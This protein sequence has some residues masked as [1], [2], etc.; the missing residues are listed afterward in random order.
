MLLALDHGDFVSIV[1]VVA[2][3]FLFSLHPPSTFCRVFFIDSTRHFSTFSTFLD[4]LRFSTMPTASINFVHVVLILTFV[5]TLTFA[6]LLL[7]FHLHSRFSVSPPLIVFFFAFAYPASCS[8]PS[9]TS[10]SLGRRSFM[11]TRFLLFRL[12]APASCS[13]PS[14]TSLSTL[15]SICRLQLPPGGLCGEPPSNT[16]SRAFNFQLPPG[17]F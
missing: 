12:F 10:L 17:G 3:L 2:S 8:E 11:M 16:K 14:I 1:I 15:A 9:I 4:D 13:E 7:N 6:S 5:L